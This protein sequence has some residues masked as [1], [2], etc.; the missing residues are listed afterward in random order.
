MTG[1]IKPVG[2]DYYSSVE[3]LAEFSGEIAL[4][5]YRNEL[6]KGSDPSSAFS[7][8]IEGAKNVLMDSGCP[9]DICDLLADAAVDGYNSFVKKNPESDPMDA[10]A[11][12]G[13]SV[14]N[15][16]DSEFSSE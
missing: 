15:A 13:E 8:A 4:E 7:S 6:E 10:F 2:E 12:A 3:D 1:D 9:C 5:I 14:N 16:L 11:A